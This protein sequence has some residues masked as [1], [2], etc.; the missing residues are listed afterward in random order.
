[1]T[2]IW[3]KILAGD[4]LR[5][6]RFHTEK[7]QRVSLRNAI[8]LPRNVALRDL[9][10][11][12]VQHPLPWIPFSAID[13]IERR[14]RPYWKVLEFGC[15]MSTV[16]FAARAGKVFSRDD[17]PAW[18][19][20]AL[21]LLGSAADNVE[22]K[23][24]T[25]FDYCDLRMFPDRY[26]DFVLI[27]GLMKSKCIEAALPKIKHEGYMFLDNSDKDRTI[28]NGD[29]PIAERLL[30]E[31]VEKTHGRAT[32]FVDFAPFNLNAQE[33]ILAFLP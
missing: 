14:I 4:D 5:P 33:S 7:G 25:G 16:W 31:A 32:A 6:T 21:A 24:A 22:I 10:A 28:V 19:D 3:K 23:V 29:T 13:V 12:G 26:F 20:R 15:G 18:R 11:A 9:R 2:T 1:V 8:N 30:R 27:D 17:N